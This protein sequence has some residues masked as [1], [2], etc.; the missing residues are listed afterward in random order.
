MPQA[1]QGRA[2]SGFIQVIPS[3]SR[4]APQAPGGSQGA[5]LGNWHLLLPPRRDQSHG[6]ASCPRNPNYCRAWHGAALLPKGSLGQGAD[7]T[8]K[9]QGVQLIPVFVG[10]MGSLAHVTQLGSPQVNPAWREVVGTPW[11]G[12]NGRSQISREGH[13]HPECW[14]APK[15]PRG[16]QKIPTASL[17][18]NPS[19]KGNDPLKLLQLLPQVWMCQGFP[20]PSCNS[21]G[22]QTVGIE[23]GR[24]GSLL[25]HQPRAA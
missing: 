24:A 16:L 5:S 9:A 6:T 8:W 14:S 3:S 22:H 2:Q 15:V 18:T 12:G 10:S 7:P 23:Q 21:R 1:Q 20:V 13:N 19:W 25:G 17:G 4:R 11:G